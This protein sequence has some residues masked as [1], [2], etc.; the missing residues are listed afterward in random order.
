MRMANTTED[1]HV[2]LFATDKLHALTFRCNQSTNKP[3]VV[4]VTTFM[5]HFYQKFTLNNLVYPGT[6]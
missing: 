1:V 3:L 4:T 5:R 6:K 2:L